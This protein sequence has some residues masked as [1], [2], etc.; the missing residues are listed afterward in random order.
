MAVPYSTIANSETDGAPGPA[1]LTCRSVPGSTAARAGSKVVCIAA[2]VQV[3]SYIA[4]SA[5]SRA[6]R[7]E[8][9]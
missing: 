2:Q 4:T 5:A 3:A 1:M 6:A 9:A 7:W 8:R